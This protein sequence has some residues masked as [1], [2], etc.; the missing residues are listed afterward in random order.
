MPRLKSLYSTAAPRTAADRQEQLALRRFRLYAARIVRRYRPF[1]RQTL[2]LFVWILRSE[3]WRL[4]RELGERATG[5]AA[6]DF[7]DEVWGAQLD[8]DDLA[9]EV[10][11]LLGRQPSRLT[12]WFRRALFAALD[13]QVAKDARSSRAEEAW[14]ESR[15][16][17]LFGLSRE[18]GQLCTFLFLCEAWTPA[19][20]YFI[21]HLGCEQLAGRKYL[22]A[23]LDLRPA[24]LGRALR[25]RARELGLLDTGHRGFR[26][27]DDYHGFFEDPRLGLG[28]GEL[29]RK[30]KPESLPLDHHLVD[31]EVTLHLLTLL[32][33][34]PTESATH[35]LIYGP[36]GTGKSSYARGIAQRLGVPVFTLPKHTDDSQARERAGIVAFANTT[37]HGQ[38]AILIVDEAD[39][40]LNTDL[41][42][43]H[44][45]SQPDKG[46]LN[47]CLER[48][49]ARMIWIT[50]RVEAIADS[51]RRRFAY[52]VDFQPLDR[53]RR[54]MIWERVLRRHRT[55]RLLGAEAV[56]EL[57]E[58]Y[59]VSAGVV[60]LAVRKAREMGLDGGSA[61]RAAVE[62]SLAAHTTLS[63]DGARLRRPDEIEAGFALE[64]LATDA[65]P[66]ELLTLV[67]GF[68][69]YLE[70]QGT[71]AG[72]RL[73]LNL[74]FHGPP[75]TGKSEL[76]RYL[77][78]RVGRQTLV[79]RASDLMHP[80][81]GMT[82]MAM[83]G[84]FAQ[85]ERDGAVLVIDEADTLLFPRE[86]ANHSWEV[87]FTNEL[88][89]Q[90][91]RFRGILICTTNRLT[92][93]DSAAT[94]RFVRKVRFD[95]LRPE[96][97]RALYAALLEP[98]A[99]SPLDGPAR[100]A[101]ERLQGLAPGD[102]RVVRDRFTVLCPDGGVPHEALVQAL[103]EEAK[104]KKAQ[105]GEKA[106]GFGAG[107][108]G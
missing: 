107:R 81:V 67:E 108:G 95:F 8:P 106:I 17:E 33:R 100:A 45:G 104:V 44:S 28:Q 82:E 50:N 88:L 89:T 64:A 80:W 41:G 102:F 59:P 1:D 73:S 71:A 22:L 9:R 93:L 65:A 38:G 61:F 29:F 43:L 19:Q 91:E 53:R 70:R 83:A 21:N 20:S 27:S 35:V 24:A 30:A 103:T 77:A 47:V 84:A 49:G 23:A 51:V 92:D 52:S 12:R 66:Q 96:G 40:L 14:P 34:A 42:W 6:K 7:A 16:T 4:C 3:L 97:A 72:P 101:L 69:R 32:A 76:A 46:W 60:D 86:R 26:V 5:E 99:G 85:A 54:V 57:A 63:R 105:L 37:T 74:L 11:R 13:R 68:H 90:M 2:E 87:S 15:L 98:L 39:R 48:P 78:R 10:I 18:E 55:G 56:Q 62:R 31:P 94:R 79:R 25:G 58:R 36:P 75:G